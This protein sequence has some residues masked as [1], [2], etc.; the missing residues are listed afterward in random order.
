MQVA[1][2]FILLNV[3][4]SF[5]A[6]AGIFNTNNIYYEDQMQSP[7]NIENISVA[8]SQESE[9]NAWNFIFTIQD[10]LTLSWIKSI[11]PSFMKSG[12]NEDPTSFETIIDGINTFLYI[13]Y[14][15][16]VIEFVMRRF[17][18]LE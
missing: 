8:N 14:L 1:V 3:S 9:I 7:S 6:T 4:M 5:I 13:L 2:F 16:A 17:G 11:A 12:I 10:Y 15:V 18:V